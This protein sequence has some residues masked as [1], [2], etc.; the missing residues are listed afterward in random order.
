ML[1][2]NL[3]NIDDVL[4][5]NKVNLIVEAASP[6]FVTDNCLK[7]LNSGKSI[8][9]MSS[10]ALTDK[11]LIKD[12]YNSCEL[13]K[14]KVHIPSGAIGGIDC[15]KSVKNHLSSVS[16]KTTKSPAALLGAPGY[17]RFENSN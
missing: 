3:N 17:K 11:N 8:M 7:I 1:L 10:G 16:I 15:I 4:N 13:N 14:V 9:I 5:D 12:I 6:K 2:T